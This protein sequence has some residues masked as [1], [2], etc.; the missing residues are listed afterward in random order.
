MSAT[1]TIREILQDHWAAFTNHYPGD[2]IRPVVHSEVKKVLSCGDPSNGFSMFCCL[3]CGAYKI[4]PFR[5]HSRFC[6]TCGVAYQSARAEAISSKLFRCHHRHIVFTIPKELRWYFRKDR[7]LLN[8]LFRS[9]AQTISD[10]LYEQ[11]HSRNFKAGMIAGLHTFGRDLKWN[12]H[13]HMI[14]TEGALDCHGIWKP[15]RFFPY[16]MLRRRFM[17]TLLSNMKEAL[18][19]D[20]FSLSDFQ[21]LTNRLY[22]TKDNGFYVHAPPSQPGS[23][24][25]IV[26][27]VI[28]YIGRPAMAQSRI[29]AYDGTNVT[30]WYQRHEDN[31]KVTVIESA[32]EFIQK[33]I[34]HIPE[35]NFHML[36][37]Y[38]LYAN[39]HQTYPEL[40]RKLSEPV[41]RIRKTL[42][43]WRYA[44]DITFGT[45]PLDCPC[46][47]TMEFVG[48]Y[49]PHFCTHPP[50]FMVEYLYLL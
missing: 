27:Y 37:Y 13:I 42:L 39:G 41:R 44:L 21:A 29:T 16:T 26:K 2:K 20:E 30:Y 6:N 3:H 43:K 31:Q 18:A 48:I 47:H 28:R 35:Q 17:T 12:P 9:A 11:N 36:R 4:V 32:F 24:D 5:C 46:G 23:T 38:G 33:L 49:H 8:V 25:T 50:P 34:I 22:Q 14:L 15:I 7:S 45:D 10:W 1:I 40:S 19:P